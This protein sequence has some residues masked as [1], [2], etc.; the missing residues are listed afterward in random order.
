M[1]VAIK[2]FYQDCDDS[3]LQKRPVYKVFDTRVAPPLRPT[4]GN[5]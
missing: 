3:A 5:D 4:L 1:E 2:T